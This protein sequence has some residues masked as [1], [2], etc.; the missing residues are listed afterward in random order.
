M[1]RNRSRAKFCSLECYSLDLQ[2]GGVE[3][4]CLQCGKLHRSRQSDF[5]SKL[6]YQRSYAASNPDK[7][8]QARRTWYAANFK[9][10]Q[11]RIRNVTRQRIRKAIRA[12][13]AV[14]SARTLELIG[15]SIPE[16]K[17]HL[18]RQF[19]EGMSWENYGTAWHI[20]HKKP[21]AVFDMNNPE[22][23][24]S[25][26]HFTNLQPLLAEDNLRKSDKWENN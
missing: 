18:E 22:H 17:M 3:R 1:G 15:C 4:A 14:K 10:S 11:E 6:C 26:F 20:D 23:Q 8:K 12:S 13:G 25:A 16:L 2:L 24:R 7:V 21:L 9:K 5:C 19:G